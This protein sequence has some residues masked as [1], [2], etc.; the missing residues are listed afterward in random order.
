MPGHAHPLIRWLKLVLACVALA[1]GGTPAQ[2]LPEADT[3]VS[4]LE[5]RAPAARRA[6]SVA[7]VRDSGRGREGRARVHARA[8]SGGRVPEVRLPAPPRR[9]FLAHRAL[10]H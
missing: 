8:P 1:L 10:L 3:V 7:A 5:R 2:A 4:V 6:E 9:L